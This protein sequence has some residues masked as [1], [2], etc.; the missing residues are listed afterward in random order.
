[1]NE[2]EFSRIEN[3]LKLIAES[4]AQHK[5]ATREMVVAS[6][7]L[8]DSQKETTNQTRGLHKEEFDRSQEEV[9]PRLIA[10][11]EL[12]AEIE[13]KLNALID[14]VDRNIRGKT[15]QS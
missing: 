8:L 3:L 2:D 11:Q 14:I 15:D 13:E 4:S 7:A 6:R 5:E 9:D 1:M 12:L 10:A